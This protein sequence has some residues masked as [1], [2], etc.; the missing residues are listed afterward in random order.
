[1][2]SLHPERYVRLFAFLLLVSL[3]T[4][5][6]PTPSVLAQATGN[7]TRYEDNSSALTFNGTWGSSNIN[8]ASGGTIQYSKTAADTASLTFDG[9]WIGVGFLTTTNGGKVE[10]SIDGVSQHTVDTYSRYESTTSAAFADLGIGPHTLTLTVLGQRNPFSSDTR[11]HLDF[12]DV[13]DGNPVADGTFEHDH[14]RVYASTNWTLQSRTEAS[15]GNYLRD[16]S[17]VWFPFTGTAVS[18]DL[19]AESR[20]RWAGR[21]RQQTSWGSKQP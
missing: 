12:I 9:P 17:N 7:I 10:I 15:G 14:G 20:V 11:I 21:S 18:V 2:S 16:G 19:M 5:L 3:V 8:Y 4:S 6:L 1:M 13:W